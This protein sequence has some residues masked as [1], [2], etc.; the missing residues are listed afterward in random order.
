MPN[1][2]NPAAV[3][4]VYNHPSTIGSVVQSLLALNLP[5]I[6][7]DDGSNEA[8]KAA[9][10]ECACSSSRVFVVT[11]SENGGKGAAVLD[12]M[13]RASRMGFT[14]VL[15]VDADGQH[16]S[17]KA[18]EMIARAQEHPDR[19]VLG[20]PVYD[21]SAPFARRF[22]R[23]LTNFWVGVNTLSSSPPDAMCGFR[24]YPLESAL[25]AARGGIGL[26]MDFDPEILVKMTWL[27]VEVESVEVNVVYP[28]DGVSHFR[29]FSD[30]A[31]I[32]KMHARLFFGMIARLPSIAAKRLNRK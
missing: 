3:V 29:A 1:K 17:S 27:G 7:V 18:A 4:P 28:I 22:G 9:I 21:A 23:K 25:E 19:L 32:S 12:G 24:V 15:Q 6:L 10:N 20:A 16:D 31:A 5:V 2:F 11:R 13:K 26:R 30:N 8:T 14:H